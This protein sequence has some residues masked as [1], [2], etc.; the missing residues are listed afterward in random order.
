[1]LEINLTNE[2]FEEEVLKKEGLVLVDFFATWCTPCQML[3]PILSQIAEESKDKIK[4]CKVN[5]D[6]QNEL[7]MKYDISSIPAIK[8]FKDGKV[9]R[10]LIGLRSKSE[11][12]EVINEYN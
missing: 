10:S 4:V 7:A 1:M 5:V 3:A 8:I 2:N 6:E 9:V 11:I 12:E